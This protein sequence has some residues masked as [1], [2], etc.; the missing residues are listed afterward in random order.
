MQS[1]LNQTRQTDRGRASR[2][3]AM[4]LLVLLSAAL[5]DAQV[6]TSGVWTGVL[7]PSL[8]R[9]AVRPMVVTGGSITL[10]MSGP[11]S[12]SINIT[13]RMG[14]ASSPLNNGSPINVTAS[15]N[16]VDC[17]PAGN[18]NNPHPPTLYLYAYIPSTG[19]TGPGGYSI[20]ATALEASTTTSNF[21]PFVTQAFGSK[22]P[23]TP[24]GPSFLI[25]QQ[26][27]AWNP[28]GM[29]GSV[30]GTL[31]INL[32]LSAVNSL[33]AGSYTGILSIRTVITQ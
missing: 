10:S 30:T 26:T 22:Q 12:L 14:T 18:C 23:V 19:L 17:S 16:N 5:G 32:N 24:P 27:Q 11:S 7:K 31:Y 1:P 20:P 29:S 9:G 8:K 2:R 3:I 28:V 13:S 25:K 21:T 33:P 6:R 4:L 15:W